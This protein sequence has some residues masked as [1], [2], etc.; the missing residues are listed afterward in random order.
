MC[1]IASQGACSLRHYKSNTK[2]RVISK[3]MCFGQ[4]T[5]AVPD[6]MV[7][8]MRVDMEILLVWILKPM[9]VRVFVL[10]LFV[11]ELCGNKKGYAYSLTHSLTHSLAHPLCDSLTY[12]LTHSLTHSLT[13]S[14]IHSL[15]HSLTHSPG[16]IL[17]VRR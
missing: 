13:Y 2:P 5:L 6:T 1:V 12:S 15:T 4:S 8:Y 9:D 7:R 14:L 11:E 17:F 3:D 10:R 16:D